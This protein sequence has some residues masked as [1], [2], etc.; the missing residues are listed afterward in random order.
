MLEPRAPGG[1]EKGGEG[2][3][4]EA[5]ASCEDVQEQSTEENST[6]LVLICLSGFPSSLTHPKEW[7]WAA[8]LVCVCVP[9]T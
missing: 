9:V 1:W 3:A 7:C 2:L 8:V 4:L 6:E 5:M